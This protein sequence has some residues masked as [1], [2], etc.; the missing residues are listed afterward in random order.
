MFSKLGILMLAA[1]FLAWLFGAI[2]KFMAVDNVFVDMTLST[3]SE[4]MSAS[5]VDAFSSAAVQDLLYT[6]FY[7][8]HLGGL[9]CG[10]G[11]ICI[12]ISMF[13]KEH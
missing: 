5:V 12:F 2:S 11:V 6:V 4:D 13:A 8:I 10:L 1:G 7:E 3:L 9:F